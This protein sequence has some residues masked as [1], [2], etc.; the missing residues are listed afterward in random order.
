[1]R[2][3]TF[4]IL[5]ALADGPM[6]GYGVI[7]A[8]AEL[9]AQRVS[10]LPGTLYNALDRLAA[11]GLV[12]RDREEIMDGRLRRYYRITEGGLKALTA[13]TTRLRQLVTV[14]ESRLRRTQPRTV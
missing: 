10:L 6:H 2:E 11:Q 14:A 12:K 8:V 9:S 3:P 5:A 13:E 4:L 7:Q 1:M